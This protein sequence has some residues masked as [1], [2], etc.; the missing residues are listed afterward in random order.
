VVEVA[1][2]NSVAERGRQRSRRQQA[3]RSTEEEEATF[4][5][6][7]AAGAMLLQGRADRLCDRG[8][9]RGPKTIRDSI[10]SIYNII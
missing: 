1:N 6:V 10:F 4:E 9:G 5:D 3:W 8:D 7:V 2:G